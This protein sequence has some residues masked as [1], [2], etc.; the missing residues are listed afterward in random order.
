MR[1]LLFSFAIFAL[2]LSAQEAPGGGGGRGRGPQAPPKNLKVLTPE[3][4]MPNMRAAEAGLGVQCGFCHVDDRNDRANDS[5]PEKV[6]ARMM[7]AM[8]KDINSKFPDGKEHVTCYTCHRG[9]QM[10][11][12][13]PPAAAQ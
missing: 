10:P 1:K 8:V 13:T 12:S 4:L 9:Q 11:V 5:K 7:F 6:T 3:T 2:V